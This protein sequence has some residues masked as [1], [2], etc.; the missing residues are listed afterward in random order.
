MFRTKI[1]YIYGIGKKLPKDNADFILDQIIRNE[2]IDIK[3]K[4]KNI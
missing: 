1:G 4:I 2:K 3:P